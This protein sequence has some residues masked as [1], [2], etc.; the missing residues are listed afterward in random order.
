M[1]RRHRNE[2]SQPTLWACDGDEAVQPPERP[3]EHSDDQAPAEET[4]HPAQTEEL[5]EQ[6]FSRDNLLR[7]LQ[8]VE[9]NRGAPGPDGMTVGRLR[10]F[11]EANWAEVQGL[12]DTGRY[13]PQPV[14]RVL[15]PKPGGGMR[16]LGVSSV[17]DRLICQAIA[18]V[19]SPIFDP[20]FSEAS[21]G[22][23]P[24]RSAHQAVDAARRYVGEGAGWV[25]DLDLD[26][27]FDTLDHDL[28]LQLVARH[29]DCRWILLYVER[30]LNA[31]LQREDGTLVR[32][33]RGTPQGSAISPL[34]ANVFL[35]YALDSWMA[36][37]FPHIRFERYSDDVIV[38]CASERQARFVRDHIAQR[39]AGW[40]LRVNRAKTRI[41]YCKDADRPG[42]HEHERFDFLGYTFRPR[43]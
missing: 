2:G 41:V 9:Q 28:V 1:T 16:E 23:R 43:L 24:G 32:R 6:V 39:L 29:T 19:L 18:Q 17:V 31:P 26:S 37:E 10:P 15:I 42:S 38:H 36:E 11:F 25:V 12:L 40:K 3:A 30:W 33:D 22:F 14:R 21:F 27:F 4:L 8:R 7:A 34:L 20:G 5:W 35:H 13:R